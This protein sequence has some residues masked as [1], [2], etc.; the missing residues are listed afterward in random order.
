MENGAHG[1]PVITALTFDNE[2]KENEDKE[3]I[4]TENLELFPSKV[5]P[6]TKIYTKTS[7]HFEREHMC[8]INWRVDEKKMICCMFWLGHHPLIMQFLSMKMALM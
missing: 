1:Q 8:L 4:L 3:T 6:K 7:Q 2:D 5:Q